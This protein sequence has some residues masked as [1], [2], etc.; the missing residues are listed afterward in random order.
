MH[1]EKL[2]VAD[3]ENRRVVVF[4][5][6]GEFVRSWPVDIAAPSPLAMSHL[7]G[8]RLYCHFTGPGSLTASRAQVF[9]ENGMLL[10]GFEPPLRHA[11]ITGRLSTAAT[12]FTSVTHTICVCKC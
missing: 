1:G 11:W 3:S 5:T 4:K 10:R 9:D 7:N 6:S 2:F 8:L 12:T